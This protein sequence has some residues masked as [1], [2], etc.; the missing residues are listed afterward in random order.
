ML[1]LKSSHVRPRQVGST[2]RYLKTAIN[3]GIPATVP[4]TAKLQHTDISET[5]RAVTTFS[6]VRRWQPLPF[7]VLLPPSAISRRHTLTPGGRR[8]HSTTTSRPCCPTHTSL[9]RPR[10]RGQEETRDGTGRQGPAGA[11]E[12]PLTH[13]IAETRGAWRGR[14][15]NRSCC[16]L[17]A[18]ERRRAEFA[19]ARR[20]GHRN[21]GLLRALADGGRTETRAQRPPV[22]R[23]SCAGRGSR[24][25]FFR[26]WN[27]SGSGGIRPQSLPSWAH[28]T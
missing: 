26:R 27:V 24:P 15:R 11:S 21:L 17:P 16:L 10:R 19:R 18:K 22:R 25:H 8:G 3:H 4:F 9:C 1:R 28:A 5:K 13:P 6:L 23:L 12:K 14:P 7:R 2:K 20:R